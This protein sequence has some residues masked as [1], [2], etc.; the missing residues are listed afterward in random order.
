[1]TQ[2]D[3]KHGY[4]AYRSGRCHCDECREAHRVRTAQT[5]AYLK[6]HHPTPVRA[7]G[8]R[9]G[10]DHYGCRCNRC[11]AAHLA[12]Y[13]DYIARTTVRHGTTQGYRHHCR[14]RACRAAW[15][16]RSRELRAR[17]RAA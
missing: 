3:V 5:R 6:R 15:T 11:V 13:E 7:H 17:R 2:S 1:M 16:A 9:N 8:T 4:N 14:C 10:Y 12:A